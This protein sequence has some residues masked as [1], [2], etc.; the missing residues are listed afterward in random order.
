MAWISL[1]ASKMTCWAT[2]GGAEVL[3]FAF[4][5]LFFAADEEHDVAL[6]FFFRVVDVDVHQEAVEL[7]FGEGVRT[8]LLDG[9]LGGHDQEELGELVRGAGDGDLALFHGF[10]QGG[11]D[12]G[13]CAIDLVGE[14]EVVEDRAGLEAELTFAIGCVVD[15]GAGD[16]GGKKVGGELDAGEAG[17]EEGA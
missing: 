13:G 4:V 5:G 2:L 12:F 3:G 16:V 15:L 7:G 14:D 8:L 11:L 17:V 6:G 1:R 9:V 10:E